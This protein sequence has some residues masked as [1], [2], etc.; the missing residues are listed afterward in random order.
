MQTIEYQLGVIGAG[1]MAEAIL[2]GLLDKKCLK[3]GEIVAYDPSANRQQVLTTELNITCTPDSTV[4][5]ACPQ[6]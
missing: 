5:G 6:V 1:N 2:R 3:P 4:P